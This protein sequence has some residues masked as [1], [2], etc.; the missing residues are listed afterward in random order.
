MLLYMCII[1]FCIF[2]YIVHDDYVKLMTQN[3][4][5]TVVTFQ[6][7]THGRY[8]AGRCFHWAIARRFRL[9]KVLSDGKC[10][11]VTP[12]FKQGNKF[13]PGNYQFF[14]FLWLELLQ[15][16]GIKAPPELHIGTFLYL[17]GE[18]TNTAGVFPMIF[19]AHGCFINGG[20]DW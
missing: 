14:T 9:C 17:I 15:Q 16:R 1:S 19:V 20:E 11:N 6:I 13:Q 10:V 18:H 4:L 5:Y 12:I 8:G 3:M 2:W 7:G